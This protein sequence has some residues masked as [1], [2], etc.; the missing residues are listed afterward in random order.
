MNDIDSILSSQ[1]VKPNLKQR[2]A[3]MKALK[4]CT[5]QIEEPAVNWR[6][7]SLPITLV[8]AFSMLTLAFVLNSNNYAPGS[9][10]NLTTPRKEDAPASLSSATQRLE[11]G[12]FCSFSVYAE[13]YHGRTAANGGV[14]DHF[15]KTCASNIHKLGTVLLCK[16]RGRQ[17][18]VVVT[19][20]LD[21]ELGKTRIDLSGGA[22]L[23]L[24]PSYDL[25]DVTAPLLTGGKYEVIE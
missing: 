17:V 1:G 5:S 19:D 20:H 16:W 6:K 11:G 24:C 8:I 22:M 3:I 4:E 15:R 14:Y 2:I 13:R 23:E 18:E 25:T 9:S 21:R 10:Q 7:R 12:G